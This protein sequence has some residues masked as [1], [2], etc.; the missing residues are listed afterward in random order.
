MLVHMVAVHMVQVAVVQ[1][2]DMAV[3][4]DGRMAAV[5][6]VGMGVMGVGRAA[7]GHLLSSQIYICSVNET[8]QKSLCPG[9]SP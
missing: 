1:I 9:L 8:R 7:H 5:L 4:Q 6:A 2:I 3:V